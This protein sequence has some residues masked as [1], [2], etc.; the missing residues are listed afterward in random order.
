MTEHD[1]VDEGFVPRTARGSLAGRIDL[2][3]GWDSP[4]V[5]EAIVRDFDLPSAARRG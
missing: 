2:S 3:G 4:E 1:A 5:N